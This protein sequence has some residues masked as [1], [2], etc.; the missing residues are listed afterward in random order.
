MVGWHCW[1]PIGTDFQS[2]FCLDGVGHLA[3]RRQGLHGWYRNFRRLNCPV[4]KD[5]QNWSHQ[6]EAM[7][8]HQQEVDWERPKHYKSNLRCKSKWPPSEK[9]APAK[10]SRNQE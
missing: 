10:I 6:V 2:R 8:L 4:G 9:Q 3:V 5:E 1:I 7:P